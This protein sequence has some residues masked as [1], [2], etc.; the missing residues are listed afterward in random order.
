MVVQVVFDIKANF[1]S[2]IVD[3]GVLYLVN[4]AYDLVTYDLLFKLVHIFIE[5]TVGWEL[6]DRSGVLDVGEDIDLWLSIGS[7]CLLGLLLG[8]LL[9]LLLGLLWILFMSGLLRRSFLECL[10]T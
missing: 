2:G 1:L 3:L 6:M 5:L 7:R 10:G 8:L 4:M 9:R